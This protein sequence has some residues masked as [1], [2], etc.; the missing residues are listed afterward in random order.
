MGDGPSV[1]SIIVFDNGQMYV[2][3]DPHYDDYAYSNNSLAIYMDEGT[4]T[5][6][7]SFS[8]SQPRVIVTD[9]DDN[10]LLVLTK[11]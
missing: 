10:I 11:P 1:G 8:Q 6:K 4:M 3:G 9:N 2:E 5:F 7:V